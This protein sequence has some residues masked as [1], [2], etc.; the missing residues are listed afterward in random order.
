MLN[1][2]TCSKCDEVKVL[3]EFSK[4]RSTRSG[5]AS[6]CKSC[7]AAY[8]K[9]NRVRIN[10]YKE[11]WRLSHPDKRKGYDR[12]HYA[13]TRQRRLERARDNYDPEYHRDWRTAN[14][15]KVRH[16]KW[17]RKA[18]ER[19]ALGRVSPNIESILW[20]KQEGLCFYCEEELVSY[21]LEHMTP[22]SRGGRHDN[23]SLCLS[24]VSCNLHKHA[25]TAEEFTKGE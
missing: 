12:K 9:K 5:Y 10:Q 23:S 3:W 22:L 16:L 6:Q 24:C 21:H 17:K 20:K 14:R 15:D 8:R 11:G 13:K 7:V 25:R 1:Y 2:K 18:Q 4:N 19:A